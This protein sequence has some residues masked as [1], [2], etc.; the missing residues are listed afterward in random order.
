MTLLAILTSISPCM[1]P[2]TLYLL[3]QCTGWRFS[4]IFWLPSPLC[5]CPLVTL[6]ILLQCTGLWFCFIISPFKW[7]RTAR[8]YTESAWWETT[9]TSSIRFHNDPPNTNLSDLRKCG[10]NIGVQE[11]Q[12]LARDQYENK[13]AN[14]PC[15]R[16]HFVKTGMDRKTLAQARGEET[17]KH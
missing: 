9:V 10:F 5:V 7:S 2:V 6:W 17:P 1:S 14:A 15:T 4:S 8:L 3:L 11:V 13:M 16:S 12:W